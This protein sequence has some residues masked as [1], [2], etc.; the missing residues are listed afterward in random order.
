MKVSWIGAFLLLVVGLVAHGCSVK[1]E[2]PI[3]PQA[4]ARVLVFSRTLGFRHNSIPDG[5][6]MIQAI[7]QQ[8]KFVVDITEDPAKFT[9][10]SLKRYSAVVF[11]STTGNVLDARQQID[12]ERYIQAGGGFVGIHSATDTEYD[13]PW[14]NQLVGAQFASHPPGT[15]RATLNIIRRGHPATDSL[16]DKWV[17]ND[18]WYNFKNLNNKVNVLITIDEKTYTGGTNG[19][20]HP[21]SWYHD[22]DGG[23]AFY[24]AGGHTRESFSEPL[25]VKHVTG[26][27][28]Y[29]LGERKPLD[30]SK[31]RSQR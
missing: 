9:E 15:P 20:F 23:R 2:D 10:D 22:F 29:A 5:I 19:D 7:G 26:G 6:R 1:S 17:R 21:M 8:L 16:P 11:M 31:A 13:W 3:K 4:P 14:Y 24:T 28:L 27:F 25:F 18:E 12:F 30:Y